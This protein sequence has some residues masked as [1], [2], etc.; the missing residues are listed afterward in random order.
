VRIA[1]ISVLRL[2][3]PIPESVA[4]QIHLG[5]PVKVHVQALNEDIEGKVSRFAGSLDLQTRTMETEI[6]FDNRNGRLLPGMYAETRLSLAER[7]NVLTVPLEAVVRNGEEATVLHVDAQNTLEE[8]HVKLGLEDGSNVE[9]ISGL[10][11]GDRV[12]IGNRSQFH[13][14]EKIQPKEVS[15]STSKSGG[16]K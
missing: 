8:R 16:E 10:A 5:D 2:V 13:N 4:G 7:K 12:V 15:A 14:G 9:V 3:L 1:Q 6:D 11:D